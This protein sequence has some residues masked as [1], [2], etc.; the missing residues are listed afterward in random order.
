VRKSGHL[1]PLDA[2]DPTQSS[3]TCKSIKGTRPT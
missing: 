1:V 3:F 2:K